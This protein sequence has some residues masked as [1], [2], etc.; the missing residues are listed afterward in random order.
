VQFAKTLLE[1]R[2]DLGAETQ[3]LNA[4]AL[5]QLLFTNADKVSVSPKPITYQA[6]QPRVSL[7]A[8]S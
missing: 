3:G 1:I 7:A 2:K 6:H 4:E 8:N 5:Q